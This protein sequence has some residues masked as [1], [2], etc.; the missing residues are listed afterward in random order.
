MQ[1]LMSKKTI[2]CKG[3]LINFNK[4]LVMGIIN[5][6]PDSFFAKS[7]VINKT[8]I[9]LKVEKMLLDG[10]DF[11]D[12]GGQSTRP[13]AEKISTEEEL[14]RVIP[15]I[16]ELSTLF[17]DLIISIDTFN[18]K[19][20]YHAVQVGASIINDV[21]AG[22]FDLEMFETVK[23]CKVPF[24][25]MH[26]KGNPKT[27]QLN[28]EYEDIVLNQLDY[29]SQKLMKLIESGIND[30][31]IGPGFG[32]GKNLTHNYELLSK[33]HVFKV[34]ELPILVGIS[35]KSMIQK[36]LNIN[37]EEALNATTA[38]NM[39]ALKNGA[40]ILRVHDVKEARQCVKIGEA[41]GWY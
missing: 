22:D 25:I 16:K 5:A 8:E 17:P 30:L 37:T 13:G 14:N 1:A 31:L 38:L 9:V 19:V 24:I 34:F 12:L 3:K 18:S 29:F 2:N 41:L 28:P 10:V 7:R 6:T 36:L 26:M 15:L 39:V 35:R 4:P 40:S 32:F 23:K 20:A 11:I 27:M 21:S 33:L